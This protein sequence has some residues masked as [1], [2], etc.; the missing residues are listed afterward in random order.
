MHGGVVSY[1]ADN[2]L[3]Y[4]GGTALS[5]PVVTSEYKINYVRPAVGERLV[6]RAMAEYVGKTQAVC[7]CRRVRRQRR[8]R[9]A[10]RDRAGHHRS[11]G[12]SPEG[13]PPMSYR[14][15]ADFLLHDWLGR[16]AAAARP[17]FTPSTSRETFDA[18][19]D[20]CERIARDKYAPVNR[21]IDTEEPRFDGEKVILPS[22]THEAYAAFVESGLL[23]G[24]HDY[25]VGGM[26]LPHAVQVAASTVFSSASISLGACGLLT[27]G[28]ANL[29]MEHGTDLQK[30][31][32][33][34]NELSGRF[35]GT[36]CLSEPQAGSSISDISTR[37][38][39]DGDDFEAT[40]LARA[41]GCAATRCGS[42]AGITSW[43]RTSSTWCSPRSPAP[44]GKLVPGTTR[45][46][47]VHRAQ[48]AGDSEGR[49]SGERND[50]ALAGLNHKLGWRGVTNALLNFG[51]G[52][53]P[54]RGA[55]GAIG[56]L[57]GGRAKACAACST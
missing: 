56:Y 17:R 8:R 21:L 36:M 1:L 34:L 13:K 42:P 10:L 49:L 26:Q 15:T 37:A 12:R 44:D 31:V 50:V 43:A 30:K 38:E 47:A 41:T 22:V 35:T 18:V 48:E 53:Y 45:H 40:R 5:V 7:R 3:T 6:A 52:K 55:A 19:L 20:T 32:F 29:L 51:E 2:A 4:A 57:V 33:A 27:L 9:E 23:L 14:R 39:P 24:G 16:A 11:A 28:N 25:D 54:V 46:L